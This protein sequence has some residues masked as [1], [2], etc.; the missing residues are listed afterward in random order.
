MI[1]TV[2]KLSPA[3]LLHYID[4]CH[5]YTKAALIRDIRQKHPRLESDTESLG[6]AL[7]MTCWVRS[8]LPQ[9]E[10]AEEQGNLDRCTA[11]ILDDL[12]ADRTHHFV[13]VGGPPNYLYD[14]QGSRTG[15]LDP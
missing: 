1:S 12:E 11:G 9:L 14:F 2:F 15:L 8:R 5:Q 10:S 13:T 3:E 6:Q 7:N 4:H